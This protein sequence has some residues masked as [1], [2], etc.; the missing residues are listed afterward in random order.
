MDGPLKA[1]MRLEM[2][3]LLNQGL[4]VA[5]LKTAWH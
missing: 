3:L 5:Y 2:P 4:F 1:F